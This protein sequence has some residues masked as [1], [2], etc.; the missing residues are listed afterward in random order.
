MGEGREGEESNSV[1]VCD[2]GGHN[3]KELR[4]RRRQMSS[5]VGFLRAA[6]EFQNLIS[7]ASFS[8]L[9][10]LPVCHSVDKRT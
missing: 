1:R 5:D 10:A 9:S 4:H 6:G 2:D 8:N 3:G 7:A